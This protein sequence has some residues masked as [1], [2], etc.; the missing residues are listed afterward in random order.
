MKRRDRDPNDPGK[1]LP[2]GE[3]SS[4]KP[5]LGFR[6]DGSYGPPTIWPFNTYTPEELALIKA[7]RLGIKIHK[8]RQIAELD[9]YNLET[10]EEAYLSKKIAKGPYKGLRD[11]LR[12]LQKQLDRQ[13]KRS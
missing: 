9:G 13:H 12:R 3:V 7:H 11:R 1:V 6:P 8:E 2:I 4:E 5:P 10:L